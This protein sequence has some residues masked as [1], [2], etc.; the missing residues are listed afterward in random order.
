M[1]TT[2]GFAQPCD[3][4][5]TLELNTRQRMLPKPSLRNG[6]LPTIHQGLLTFAK[7]VIRE[8]EKVT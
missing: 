5:P 1:P 6:P 3:H 7:Q 4:H 8:S 2:A